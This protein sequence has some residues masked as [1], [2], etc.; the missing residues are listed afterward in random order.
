MLGKKEEEK[1]KEEEEVKYDM[2]SALIRSEERR[3]D[4]E[5]WL[6]S[7]ERSFSFNLYDIEYN[8]KLKGRFTGWIVCL[9]GANLMSTHSEIRF[10]NYSD[11]LEY[12]NNLIKKHQT[13]VNRHL[14]ETKTGS[15][16]EKMNDEEL[17]V[18]DIISE[19]RCGK[20]LPIKVSI[21]DPNTHLCTDCNQ[22]AKYKV[23]EKEGDI[24]YYCGMCSVGM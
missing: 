4:N 10:K 5:K 3:K 19:M 7:K 21:V 9:T 13:L 18:M 16:E 20:H 14:Y 17:G 1:K 11:A 24:W 6:E 2:I 22:P 15:M 23:F 8:V 12:Y